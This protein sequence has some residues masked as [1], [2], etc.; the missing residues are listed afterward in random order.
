MM[1]L[2]RR[3]DG[4]VKAAVADNTGMDGLAP[5]FG[6]AQGQDEVGHGE[7]EVVGDDLGR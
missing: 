5:F 4:G 6:L 3:R 1:A 7:R 2:A